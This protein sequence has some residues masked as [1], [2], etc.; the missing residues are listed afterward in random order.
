M[1]VRA[2]GCVW[3][4]EK[5][6]VNIGVIVLGVCVCV[7]VCVSVNVCEGVFV[8]VRMCACVCECV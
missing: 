5:V 7:N 1:R 3:V 4:F 2:N 6:C 8:S